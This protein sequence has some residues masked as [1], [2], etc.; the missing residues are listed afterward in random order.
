MIISEKG[1]R[2]VIKSKL[3]EGGFDDRGTGRIGRISSDRCSL[4]DVENEAFA[5]WFAKHFLFNAEGV[6]HKSL[7]TSL[8]NLGRMGRTP[9]EDEQY[10][11]A[12]KAALRSDPTIIS[13]YRETLEL[14]IS[15]TLGRTQ[16][17]VIC[18][19]INKFFSKR[20]GQQLQQTVGAAKPDA[21]QIKA[22]LDAEISGAAR[23][24]VL[25]NPS[26]R[27]LSR[28]GL[29]SENL[30]IFPKTSIVLATGDAE[31]AREK[32]EEELIKIKDIIETT[33]QTKEKLVSRIG[34]YYYGISGKRIILKDLFLFMDELE[35]N[36]ENADII[37]ELLSNKFNESARIFSSK[38]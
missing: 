34:D 27:P 12:V 38:V 28:I 17:A 32:F 8:K 7:M 23:Q 6:S 24:F 11:K 33:N 1:I 3:S 22:R 35:D 2:K 9:E 29:S 5:T 13:K 20:S 31:K 25:E 14:G 36:Y 21:S 4:K 15:L 18:A 16:G 26:V 30:F 19:I 10:T 37:R